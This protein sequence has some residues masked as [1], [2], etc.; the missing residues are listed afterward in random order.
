MENTKA[1]VETRARRTAAMGTWK[2]PG[3]VHSS[4]PV[5]TT[6]VRTLAHLKYLCVY[7]SWGQYSVTDMGT[8]LQAGRFGV[9]ILAEAT[10]VPPE[11]PHKL[12]ALPSL[13][14]NGY[15]FPFAGVMLPGYGGDHSPPSSAEVKNDMI[16]DII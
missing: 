6:P 11:H 16:Y 12:C 13:L 15:R 14:F 2:C 9:R 10:F 8:E 1:E 4:V 5:E 7:L 3:L